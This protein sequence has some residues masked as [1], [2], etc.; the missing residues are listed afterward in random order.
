MA[1]RVFDGGNNAGRYSKGVSME[2]RRY[3]RTGFAAV[4][5]IRDGASTIAAVVVDVALKGAL[6]TVE[7]PEAVP[8]DRQ[9]ELRIEL[10]GAPV[11]ITTQA[12][13]VHRSEDSLG[14]RFESIDAESMT[15][16]RRLLELNTGNAEE[17]TS[18][19]AFLIEGDS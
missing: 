11:A 1:A 13:C 12:R 17:I 6:V 3:S 14:F 19:L 4:G 2:Q 18:E 7:K 9:V 10:S 16:L 15:H 8:S 5:T